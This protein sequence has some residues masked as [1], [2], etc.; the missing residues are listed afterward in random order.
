MVLCPEYLTFATV[1]CYIIQ[2]IL[3]AFVRPFSGCPPHRIKRYDNF[4]LSSPLNISRD[5]SMF[6]PILSG[7]SSHYFGYVRCD[8]EAQCF[9]EIRLCHNPF[10][11]I[12][13]I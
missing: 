12:V 4:L 7:I 6:E 9:L 8:P 11:I 3:V 2:T 5:C 1:V 10:D 13:H